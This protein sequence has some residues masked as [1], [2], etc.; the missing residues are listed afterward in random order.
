MRQQCAP[1][2]RSS[3]EHAPLQPKAARRERANAIWLGE[4]C[5][6]ASA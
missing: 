3:I 5:C 2:W 6:R 1:W 4:S